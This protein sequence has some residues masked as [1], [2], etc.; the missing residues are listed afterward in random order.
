MRP[1]YTFTVKPSLPT[2][3]QPLQEL[4]YNLMWCWDHEMIALFTRIDPDLWEETAH[5]PVMMLGRVKQ[6]R[7]AQLAADDGFL[8]EVRRA[9]QRIREYTRRTSWYQKEHP[10]PCEDALVA[11]FSMEFGLTESLQIYTGGLGILAG[12]HLKSASDLGVPLVGVGLLYQK[13]YFHQYLNADGWQQESYPDNDF[14]N[15]PLTLQRDENGDPLLVKV[16]YPGRDV[17]AQIWR[18]DVGRVRL[19]LLDTN[20]EDNGRPDQDIT[21]YLYGGDLDMRLRQEIML[22]IGGVRALDV[23]GIRPRVYHMNE[24]H[25]AFLA[26]EHTRL[27]MRE[28]GLSFDQAKELARAGAVFTTHTPVPAGIDRFPSDLIGRYFG[29]YYGELGLDHE[30]FMA[31]GRQ[32]AGDPYEPF[33]MAILA[34][35]MAAY[36]NAVSKLHG[37]VSRRMWQGVWPGTP[38]EEVPIGSVTNGIHQPSW[39]SRDMASLYERYLGPRWRETPADAEL[40]SRVDRIPGAELWNTHERRR[41][42][43]VAFIRRRLRQQV[44]RRG[45]SQAELLAAEEVLNPE[46]LTI[47]FARRFATYKRATLLLQDPDRLARILGDR[48]RPVQIVFAGKAHPHDNPG[49][50]LIRQ[51]VHMARREE[52]RLRLVFVENYD[53]NIARYLLQG[54]DVWLNTPIRGHEAS[55]TSGIKAAANGVLNVSILDGWWNEAYTPEIGWAIGRGEEYD[56]RSLQ[57]HVESN[58]LYNLLEQEVIPLFYARGSDGMPRQWLEKMKAS[59]KAV[60]PIFN[61]HRMLQEY[62]EKY[63]LPARS[64]YDRLSS[65]DLAPVKA[66]AAWKERVYRCWPEVRIEDVRSDIPSE[67]A[68]GVGN[69]VW[70]KIHLGDLVPDDVTVELYHGPVDAN[71]DIQE[72]RIVEMACDDPEQACVEGEPGTYVFSKALTCR[73]S[74]MHGFTV[75]VVPRHPEQVNAFETGL[76]LWG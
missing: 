20:I 31:L 33:C 53:M 43:L 11:Y 69:N 49:K 42:R 26:L 64:R 51:I 48:D 74:G 60:C 12:D 9:M 18:V 63:Y 39:V 21:D 2:E 73:S 4:A 44:A 8:N 22:G 1:L 25:S 36:T 5:N 40:W 61:T 30:R 55:G 41:E 35:R 67:T 16:A 34:L 15:L 46:A 37:R 7:F 3:L 32:N 47:G 66:Y 13:G 23:L 6:E 29:G 68:V 52:L 17:Y 38:A 54:V 19:Y 24:G 58:A 28:H 45:G 76:V 71:G 14:Y 57:D 10:D 75:R 59:M 56:D 27:L 62:T 72:P 50:E 70:A 65:D